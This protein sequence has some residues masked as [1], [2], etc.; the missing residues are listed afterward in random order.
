MAVSPPDNQRHGSTSDW[1]TYPNIRTV[2]AVTHNTTAASRLFD[3]LDLLAADPRIRINFSCPGS[4]HFDRDLES[5]LTER[6]VVAVPWH[7]A[8][9]T[10]FDLAI[11]ASYGGELHRLRAPLI[12]LPH[13]AGHNKILLKPQTSNLKSVFGLSP[14]WLLHDGQ[15]FPSAIVLSHNEQLERLRVSCP[16]AVPKALVA[17][18]ICFDRLRA[19]TPLRPS[20]RR[21]YGLGDGQRLIVMS[22]TWGEDS[23]LG[24]DSDL[25]RKLAAALPVD[26]YRV[27]LALHPNIRS[28]HSRWE[29]AEYLAGATRAGVDVL[30]SVRDWRTAI[31]AADLV[32]GDHG[33][34]SFYAA[35]LGIP[36]L[37]A[38]APIH[39]VD[40][41][42][43]VALL[44]R[45]APKLD[46]ATNTRQQIEHAI[47]SH[48]P[49]EYAD[50][51]A[52]ATSRPGDGAA[53]LRAAVYRTLR[54]PEPSE[55]AE[56][57]TLPLPAH[58]LAGPNAH[59]V[60]VD[61]D[62]DRAATITRFP[63]E[64][65]H[66][67]LSNGWG[68][69]LSV[70]VSETRAQW[71]YSADVLI[72]E[73][74]ANTERWIAESLAGLPGCALATAPTL[75]G[76]WLVGDRTSLLCVTAS[77]PAHRLFVSVAYQLKCQ[78]RTLGELTGEWVIR[79]ATNTFVVTVTAAN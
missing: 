3:T 4:S 78:G 67:G 51:A 29:V 8:V 19:S 75:D 50:L 59:V 39:A 77:D 57:S 71:L 20:Y 18:D 44:L 30:D 45:T 47:A 63:A 49:P 72:G 42:S 17:G 38:S 55:P 34:I 58:P 12:V 35:A 76:D 32:I 56:I 5:F 46:I 65:L 7:R 70:E 43:P 53:T 33:S 28:L 14:E 24:T 10:D 37:L 6:G 60:H 40:P 68:T 22:T 15:V 54:L 31:V 69:H 2:L 66:T 16:A 74:G 79:C 41:A 36:V 21:R 73:A 23:L 27:V 62:A 25:P 9:E 48:N 11:S 61:I 52:L 1:S 64:R 26:E 13:G